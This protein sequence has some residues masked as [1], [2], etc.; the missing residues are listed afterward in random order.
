MSDARLDPARNGWIH[1]FVIGMAFLW[2]GLLG[3]FAAMFFLLSINW[4]R[5]VIDRMDPST[6]PP[7]EVPAPVAWAVVGATALATGFIG[8]HF[9][10]KFLAMAAEVK[11][12]D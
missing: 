2:C 7:A 10:R 3:F 1:W 6:T 8:R 11:R 5:P 9:A 12:D 4:L